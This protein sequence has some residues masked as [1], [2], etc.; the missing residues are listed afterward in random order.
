M[1]KKLLLLL[2]FT[3]PLM[4][5]SLTVAAEVVGKNA[6]VQ[7]SKQAWQEDVDKLFTSIHC[8]H[9]N[10][11]HSITVKKFKNLLQSIVSSSQTESRTRSSLKLMA[12]LAK[13]A[14]ADGDGRTG[15]WPFQ[16]VTDF[17]LLP[18][19]LYSFSDGIYILQANN[20]NQQLIGHQLMA[21]AGTPTADVFDTVSSHLGN[22]SDMWVK[23]W[24]PL[25]SIIP[26]LLEELNLAKGLNINITIKNSEGELVTKKLKSISAKSY[27]KAF[28]Q[29]LTRT[30]STSLPVDDKSA[31]Y[32]KQIYGEAYWFKKLNDS[33]LYMQYNHI[34][35]EDEKGQFFSE[36]MES[37]EIEIKSY[38]LDSLIIDVRNIRGGT[39]DYDENHA[40]YSAFFE[41][42]NRFKAEKRQLNLYVLTGRVA[43][44]TAANFVLDLDKK[45]QAIFIGEAMGGQSNY[46]GEAERVILPNSK[47][48]VMLTTRYQNKADTAKPAKTAKPDYLIELSSKQFY[49]L[50]DPVML[51]TLALI[52]LSTY[53]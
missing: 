1:I 50:V 21:I 53:D 7:L 8:L 52:E 4:S 9:P 12:A 20:I 47:L 44:S 32:L 27:K 28:H 43:F 26:E 22:G 30:S 36:F 46:Y 24:S 23:S 51:K 18:L 45:T 35:N 6:L 15:I 41:M 16:D 19:R 25:Y 38:Q 40:I 33:T 14:Q 5:V 31:G 29:A 48:K 2:V 42:L 13:I 37:L 11:W 10:P 17:H 39:D 49:S 3:I 34:I